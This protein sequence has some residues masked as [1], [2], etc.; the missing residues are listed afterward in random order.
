M[1]PS[2]RDRIKGEL[3]EI[4]GKAKEKVGHITKRK[5]CRQNPKES[6]PDQK[7]VWDV[8]KPGSTNARFSA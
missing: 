8:D 5:I 3:H 2:M 1:K 6:R 4:K 7:G